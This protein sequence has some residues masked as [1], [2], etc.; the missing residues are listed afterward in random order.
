MKLAWIG[1]LGNV[2]FNYVKLLNEGGIKAFLFFPKINLKKNRSGNPE[3]EWKG[4]SQEP[5]ICTYYRDYVNYVLN[6]IGVLGPLSRHELYIGR[7]FNLIQAQTGNEISAL[8]I[9]REFGLPYTGTAT[10]ADL[11]ELAF[12]ESPLGDLY[13]K[14]LE[15]ASHLFLV[16]IDQF[17]T[18]DKLSLKLNSCSF[19]PFCINFDKLEKVNNQI[20]KKIVFYSVARLDWTS[21]SRASIKR[22][23]I[24]F[25]GFA[26]YIKQNAVENFELRIADWGVD[27]QKTRE[28][29]KSLGIERYVS[30]IPVG[31]KK[32]FYDNLKQANIVVD[33][34]KL[35][36]IGMAAFES[37]AM[38]RPVFAF[39]DQRLAQK[40]YGVEIPVINCAN[41]EEICQ[42]LKLLTPGY[43]MEKSRQS[44]EWVS[45]YHSRE[46]I[47]QILNN[48]YRCI[49]K[50]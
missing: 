16:N 29:I 6:R 40:A 30:F 50:E 46:Y 48:T 5:F 20:A 1:N 3:R 36:A 39:C 10:G 28:L 44:L 24:F 21:S 34:F 41:E 7:N 27:R 42:N 35:G 15:E 13:R 26:S 2:G 17:N 19:L 37:M 14:A 22:N 12:A 4:A 33:Q 38:C 8:R 9:K 45:K 11:S 23:D 47:F 43:V 18:L 25:K 32:V 49:H 31:V